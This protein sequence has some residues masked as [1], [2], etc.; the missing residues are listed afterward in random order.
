MFVGIIRGQAPKVRRHLLFPL[1]FLLLLLLFR[2]RFFRRKSMAAHR[3]DCGK[4]IKFGKLIDDTVNSNDT[5]FGVS[6]SNS[7]AP[8]LVQKFNFEMLINFEP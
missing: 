8:P 2:F 1:A 4:V 6:N 7:L 3:T 5:K